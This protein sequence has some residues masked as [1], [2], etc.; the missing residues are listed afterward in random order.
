MR[1]RL[2]RLYEEHE[3]AC[4][5]G[6]FV[7][8]FLFDTLA[9]GRIDAVHNIL[10]QALYLFLCA[11]FIGLELC[12]VYG[13]FVPPE[14]LRPAWRYQAGATHFM[15]GTLLNIYTL[16]YFKSASLSVS[17]LFMCAL[18][19]LLAVNELRPFERSGTTMRMVL[20]S[21]C[22]V[23]YF[24]YLVPVLVGS[25]G[26]LV[27][28]GSLAAAGASTALLAWWLMRR[29]PQRR[30]AV[31]GRVVIPFSA[32]AAAFLALYLVKL[33]PPVPL[34]LREIGVYHGVLR[35][36][37]EFLLTETRPRWRFWERG[38]QT[39]LARPGDRVACFVSVFSPTRFAE[40]L[41]VRWA[42]DD[43]KEGWKESDAI[44]LAVTGGRDKGWR[45]ATEKAR[46]KPG[47]WR[48]RVV[49]S[50]GRELGRI[51][52]RV[53]PDPSTGARTSRLLIR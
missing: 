5:A 48:V 47:R 20:F 28:L 27:F 51:S 15:L 36:G 9:V 53:E 1:E 6:L 26:P 37:D 42:Y 44:G 25:I 13:A 33:V 16:F 3:P 39:F 41:S 32:T 38:D 30:D 34:S 21:L 22:L 52:L 8:G 18:A 29:L 24:G 11:W 2:K 35:R 23:S 46:W 17:F 31:W 7:A 12:E 40:R 49:T 14:R 4:T 45:G 19:S 50:D 43:P 10:H